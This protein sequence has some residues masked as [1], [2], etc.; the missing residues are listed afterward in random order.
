MNADPRVLSLRQPWASLVAANEKLLETR[1]W[2]TSWRG[3]LLIHA[4]GSD[5]DAQAMERR[6]IQEA[7]ERASLAGKALPHG[8][9]L[10]ATSLLDCWRIEMGA[11]WG[12]DGKQ[13]TPAIVRTPDGGGMPISEREWWLGQYDAGR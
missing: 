8:A 10:C 5:P 4:S 1:S 11:T 9:I 3:P 6:G 12:W 13:L 2:R 7:L